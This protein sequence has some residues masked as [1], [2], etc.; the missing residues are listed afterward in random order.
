[1]QK[2]VSS[3]IKKQDGA[4]RSLQGGVMERCGDV[5]EECCTFL[6]GSSIVQYKN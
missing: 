1:M 3:A 6:A 2:A 4:L 5:V